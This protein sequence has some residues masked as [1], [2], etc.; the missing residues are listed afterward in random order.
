MLVSSEVPW[1]VGGYFNF[2]RYPEEKVGV[3]FNTVPMGQFP[4]FIESLGLVDL[5]INGGRYT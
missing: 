2:I 4:D 5:S 1:I 3:V